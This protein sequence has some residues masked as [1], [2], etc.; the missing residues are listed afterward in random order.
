MT[1]RERQDQFIAD[2]DLFDHWTDRFNYLI[3]EGEELPET[4]PEYLTAY[5]I[6]GCQ[7]KTC[8]KVWLHEGLLYV[9]GW[10]NSAVMGG[11]IVA[12]TKIF[13]FSTMEELRHTPIDFH[14]KTGLIDNL[15]SIRRSALEEMIRRIVSLTA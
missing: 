8:F 11:I 6:E 5:R 9:C 10:S 2:M 15:T 13:N 14:L 1:L 4:F 3:S 7:S 12:M